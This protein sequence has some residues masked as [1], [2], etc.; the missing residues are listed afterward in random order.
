MRELGI[1]VDYVETDRFFHMKE[2]RTNCILVRPQRDLRKRELDRSASAGG[3]RQFGK[4]LAHRPD[5][6]SIE[7]VTDIE[8][9]SETI[10]RLKNFVIQ[11]KM[12]VFAL[13][14]LPC[15][16]ACRIAGRQA[17]EPCRSG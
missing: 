9:K 2:V 1:A 14:K 5:R 13:G 15:R 12:D 4:H 16:F 3:Q 10:E 8:Q 7:R 11:T 6:L 17:G